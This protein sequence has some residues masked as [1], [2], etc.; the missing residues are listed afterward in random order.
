MLKQAED[1]FPDPAEREEFVRAMMAGESRELCIIVMEDRPEI[2]T[3][4]RLGATPWQ[5]EFVIRLAEGFK[6]SKHALYA[7]GAFYSLDFSSVFSASAMLAIPD[8]PKSV[9]DLCAAPGGKAVFAWR[10]FRP[11]VLACNE[12]IR[13]RAGTLIQNLERCKVEAAS[14]WSADPSVWPKKCPQG[15]DM[16]VVDAP[17]SGQSLLAKGDDAPD[18]FLPSMIEM[19][20]GRQRRI[21]AHAA[22]CVKPG[23]HLLYATCTFSIKENEK[24]MAWLMKEFPHFVAAEV[25]RLAALQSK[26]ADFPCYRLFPHYGIGA[27]AF[28]ALL[29]NTAPA[30]EE[31]AEL[32][33]PAWWRYGDPPR[34]PK[35]P[36][37]VEGAAT[38][39]EEEKK[40]AA[41]EKK[42]TGPN[43]RR[44][45]ELARQAPPARRKSSPHRRGRRGRG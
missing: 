1:L 25:P 44:R 8:A 42:F 36:E 39:A 35:T 22:K 9:L 16:V 38:E 43:R 30:P 26:Y 28:V 15:F 23:G 40:P 37:P 3:F 31:E 11:Q 27:G 18:C 6:A 7:K 20:V 14:V 19:N 21:A 13:K 10:A 32:V 24:V 2:R 33:V 5:P 45:K 29:R 41:P 34:T 17:C 12:T 4:P